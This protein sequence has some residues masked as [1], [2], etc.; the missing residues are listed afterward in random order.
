[1]STPSQFRA[2]RS[3]SRRAAPPQQPEAIPNEYIVVFKPHVT[4]QQRSAHRAW[5][6]EKH[7]SVLSTRGRGQATTGLLHKFNILNGQC[8]GYVAHVPEDVIQQIND[9]DEVTYTPFTL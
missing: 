4:S 3:A 2:E 5:A 6:A 1:M 7:F 8:A 9:T